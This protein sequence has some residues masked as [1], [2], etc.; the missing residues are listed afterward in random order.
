MKRLWPAT[1]TV[2]T[3]LEAPGKHGY[4]KLLQDCRICVAVGLDLNS[5]GG[6]K[7]GLACIKSQI[8]L[9]C[10]RHLS[11]TILALIAGFF[12]RSIQEPKHVKTIS[13]QLLWTCTIVSH[14]LCLYIL[15][16]ILPERRRN[17]PPAT[18]PTA[19]MEPPV[20]ADK[21]T[22][23]HNGASIGF[24]NISM[25]AFGTCQVFIFLEGHVDHCPIKRCKSSG[26][27]ILH[28]ELCF[29]GP[30]R[31][32]NMVP[33]AT[34]IS[35]QNVDICPAPMAHCQPPLKTHL[36]RSLTGWENSTVGAWICFDVLDP[37]LG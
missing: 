7:P 33:C 32:T 24:S 12:T 37:L 35:N 5:D 31:N 26:P 6:R 4:P 22:S 29:R 16:Y 34:I 9:N 11:G 17:P 36:L 27:I 19:S 21:A 18:L 15:L 20:P 8:L 13:G 14:F 25:E 30:Q 28:V 3:Y 1:A 10:Q 2:W 23:C